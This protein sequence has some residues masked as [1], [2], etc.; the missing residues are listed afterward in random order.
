MGSKV[1]IVRGDKMITRLSPLVG[2]MTVITREKDVRPCEALCPKHGVQCKLAVF[3]QEAF[4][5]HAHSIDG[6]MCTWRK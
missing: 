1:Q 3:E 4:P 2:I 6:K 5:M